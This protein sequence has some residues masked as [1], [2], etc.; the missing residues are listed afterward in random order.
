MFRYPFY[1]IKKVNKFSNSIRLLSILNI[2]F[3]INLYFETRFWLSGNYSN[4]KLN[5]I[6]NFGLLIFLKRIKKRKSKKRKEKQ[7]Y[8]F[9]N[10]FRRKFKS[11]RL[12]FSSLPE[13]S[14][15]LT[16]SFHFS[17]HILYIVSS[18]TITF[19]AIKINT[20]SPD[21]HSITLRLCCLL[22]YLLK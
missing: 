9:K 2:I 10:S 4:K 15:I 22:I 17:V 13:N 12:D 8:C 20:I 7:S 19:E 5:N 3:S 21:S 11:E 6:K 1:L 14:Y 16:F 18:N